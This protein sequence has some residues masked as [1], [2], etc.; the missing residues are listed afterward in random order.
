MKYIKIFFIIA[1]TVFAGACTEE[2]EINE[3]APVPGDAELNVSPISDEANMFLFTNSNEDAFM[4]KW[5]FSTGQIAEGDDVELYVPFAGDYTVKLTVFTAG[6]SAEFESNFTVD[7]TDPEICNQEMLAL[8]TGGCGTPEGKTW[9]IDSANAGHFGLGPPDATSPIWYAA[10][11]LEKSGGGMYDDRYTFFLNNYRYEMETNG[12]VYLNGGQAPDFPGAFESEVGDYT[13]PFPKPEITNYVLESENGST[14][15]TI[16]GQSFIGY[17]T[18]VRT[19]EV[20]ELTENTMTLKYFDTKN[21]FSWYLNLIQEG[22]DPSTGGG[23]VDP[24]NLPIDFENVATGFTPFGGSSF[25]VVDNPD[26]SGINTSNK[27]AQTVHGAETWAG[28]SV[29]LD[30]ALDFSTTP[31]VSIKVWSPVA[32]DF[33]FKFEDVSDPNNNI[34]I[35]KTIPEANKWVEMVFDFSGAPAGLARLVVFPGFNSTAPET[36]YFDDIQIWEPP[37]E[38][39]IDFES[40]NTNFTTFGGSSFEVV[41]NPDATGIN[42]SSRVAKTVH[43][44]ETWAGMSVEMESSIDLATNPIIKVKV[45][46]PVT[47]EFLLKLEDATD[48]NYAVE[49]IQNVTAAQQWVELSFDFTGEPSDFEKLVVFPG[50]GVSSDDTFYFDDIIATN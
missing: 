3:T 5:E 42:T 32:G 39:P 2:F 43:G 41:D 29:D 40:Y 15:L 23:E 48:S 12:D 47:G 50:W 18:G 13:S 30:E 46:A 9:V 6:G 27:V 20:L 10:G 4:K 19:Y 8:L 49:Q 1:A 37:V 38:F 34:E 25:E 11:A 26:K 16:T 7:Q 21:D 28:L 31:F 44:N 17:F 45:W 14:T 36:F 24:V 33:Q 35:L 22:Y